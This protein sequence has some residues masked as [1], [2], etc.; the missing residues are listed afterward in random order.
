MASL[1]FYFGTSTV[2][3]VIPSESSL[4][5]VM[6]GGIE[7]DCRGDTAKRHPVFY[8]IVNLLR[9]RLTFCMLTKKQQRQASIRS[10]MQATLEFIRECVGQHPSNR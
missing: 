3:S 10:Q 4:C 5:P 2:F 1:V 8:K 7:N 9:H 6:G